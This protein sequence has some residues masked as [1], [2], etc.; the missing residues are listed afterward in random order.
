LQ[1]GTAEIRGDIKALDE[2]SKGIDERLKSVEF[3]NRS[4]GVGIL[5]A[6]VAAVIKL[7]FPA[8]L[9]NP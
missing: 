9:S 2:K 3:I 5:V 8:F 6:I 4:L 1:V 7:L